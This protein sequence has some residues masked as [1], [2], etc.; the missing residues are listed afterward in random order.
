M[1]K[2]FRTEEGER[3]NIVEHT[4]EQI[5]KWPNLTIR[6]GTDSQNYSGV[7][8]YVTAIVFR[9]GRRGAHY[10]YF[11]EEVPRI[12]SEWNRLYDEGLRTVQ[13]AEMITSEIPIAVEAL[14]FDYNDAKKTLSSQL[15]AV[16]KN[17]GDFKAEFKSGDMLACKAA[18]H[19]CRK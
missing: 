4:L 9:Y 10:I 19:I 17:W 11:K 13:A 5:E 18:D 14:E 12:R 7:T 16:F 2:Y 3:V 1:D 6:I 8:R 15:V